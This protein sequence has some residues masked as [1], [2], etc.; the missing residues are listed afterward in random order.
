M[1]T[2]NHRLRRSFA[3]ASIVGAFAAPVA[4]AAVV[5]PPLP[6]P[7]GSQGQGSEQSYPGSINA[8]VPPETSEP[9]TTVTTGGSADGF[10]WGDAG[11]GAA[12]M[13]AIGAMGAGGVLA[14][15]HR[16]ARHRLA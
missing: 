3:I 15:G 12:G 11:L 1:S 8:I 16:R 6:G 10:D 9:V 14:V 4:S 5:D 13:L 2:R 7:D